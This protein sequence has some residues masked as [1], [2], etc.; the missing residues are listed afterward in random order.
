MKIALF[1]TLYTPYIMGGAEKSTQLLAEQLVKKGFDVV[2]VSTGKKDEENIINGVKVYYVHIPNI[3]WRYDANSQNSLKRSIWRAIDYYNVF[4][5]NKIEKILQKEKPDICHTNNIG[6]FSVSLWSIIKKLNFPLVHTI[7]DYYSIC[8]TS[9]MLKN[10]QSCEKQCLECKIYTYNKKVVSQKVDAVTGVSKFILDKHLEHGYFKNAKIKTY[11]YN[12]ILKIDLEFEKQNNK[13]VIFGYFGLISSIK[14]V[15]LLLENF[16]KIDNPNIRLIL[17]GKEHY[18]GYIEK[19][20]Q[21]YND[22][23]VEFIGFVKPEDFFKKIDVLIHPTLWFE[24]FARS[25]IE[26]FSY[27]VPVIASYKGGNIEAIDENKTGFL[28]KNQDEL[29]DKMNFFI[30]NP[31]EIVKM[32]DECIK[33]A[34]SLLVENIVEEYIGVYKE[35]L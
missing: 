19:L 22:E 20:K 27:K 18:N 2:V 3:F 32:Q 25:I 24:P 35:L 17:A 7:R 4:T 8:A 28:F 16:Q 31:S 30:D 21:K 34:K 9:K 26:A 33:K 6:G 13:N 12:P 23:R 14:G 11:I 5:F 15:E 29:I 10:G 1:N